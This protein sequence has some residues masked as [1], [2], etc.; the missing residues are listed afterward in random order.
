MT[1]RDKYRSMSELDRA[2]VRELA[3]M[4]TALVYQE[5]HE[6]LV[7]EKAVFD[8]FDM[9]VALAELLSEDDT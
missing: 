7:L 4:F 9:A 3:E 5:M 6:G 8:G 1:A 2:A